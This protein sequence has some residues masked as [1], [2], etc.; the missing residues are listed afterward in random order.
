MCIRDRL[1]HDLGG[2]G[3]AVTREGLDEGG[4][5]HAGGDGVIGVEDGLEGRLALLDLL[6]KLG[7]SVTGGSGLL[8]SGLALL[9]GELRK[10]HVYLQNRN[11]H[12]NT[13]SDTGIY[14]RV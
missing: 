9:I 8:E 10:R 2:L 12:T 13:G 7:A 3:L 1:V 11:S 4:D 14:V 5:L 6:A